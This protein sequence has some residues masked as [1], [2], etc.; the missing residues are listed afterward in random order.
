MIMLATTLKK[1]RR[2]ISMSRTSPLLVTQQRTWSWYAISTGNRDQ[3]VA[4][5]M[6]GRIQDMMRGS[7]ESGIDMRKK[8]RREERAKGQAE[9]YLSDA[10]TLFPSVETLQQEQAKLR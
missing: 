2:R 10:M 3:M 6:S 4:V 7:A 9:V 1:I 8:K 5:R